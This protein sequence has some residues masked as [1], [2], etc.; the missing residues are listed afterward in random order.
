MRGCEEEN[1]GAGSQ[2]APTATHAS[3]PILPHPALSAVVWLQL[4]NEPRR[5]AGEPPSQPQ[6]NEKETILRHE[7]RMISSK[8]KDVLMALNFLT[9]KIMISEIVSNIDIMIHSFTLYI[10]RYKKQNNQNRSGGML[11]RFNGIKRNIRIN[12]GFKFSIM[13]RGTSI[14]HSRLKYTFLSVSI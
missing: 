12:Q 1:H 8:A 9:Y 3:I 6:N 7:F 14:K 4:P 2:P 11:H 5:R 13:C 10:L